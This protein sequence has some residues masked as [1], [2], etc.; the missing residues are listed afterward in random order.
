MLFFIFVQSKVIN[1]I[2]LYKYGF[3]MFLFFS[4]IASVIP[5]TLYLLIL[6]YMD[7]YEREPLLFVFIHFLW[8]AFGAIIF[9]I[10]GNVFII[11][12][13]KIFSSLLISNL[14]ENLISNLVAAPISEE[15]SKGIFLLFTVNSK[16]F[17]NITDG[18]VYGGAIGLGFG[19]TE[20]FIYFLSFGISFQTWITLVILRSLSSAIMHCIATSIVGAFLGISKFSS[21]RMKYIFP[22]SGILIA[23]MI[24]FTWNLSV[25]NEKTFYLGFLFIILLI[26]FYIKIFSYSINKEKLIIKNELYEESKLNLIPP[27]HIDIICSDARFQKGW[28]NEEIRKKYFRTAIALAFNKMQYKKSEG[29]QKLFYEN[30]VEKKRDLIKTLL[31]YQ[32][33]D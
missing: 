5:M 14:P 24:H 25:S 7:K 32:K 6:W 22:T 17:D 20:N 30:E 15:I 23:I 11:K 8:G 9:G 3:K 21:K 19:M 2:L 28:I 13:I 4:F 26:I 10:L 33:L 27:E 31:A 16:K 1:F 18:L 12:S 29:I